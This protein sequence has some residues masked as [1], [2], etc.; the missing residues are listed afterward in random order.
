MR[1]SIHNY[2]YNSLAQCEK[3]HISNIRL[4]FWGVTN[5]STQI[6]DALIKVHIM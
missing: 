4:T 2:F 3:I 6:L 5:S 1:L